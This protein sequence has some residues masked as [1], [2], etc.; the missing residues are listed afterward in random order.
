MDLPVDTDTA[1]VYEIL[2]RIVNNFDK[3]AVRVRQGGRL[4]WMPLNAVEDQ[5]LVL[6]LV[7]DLIKQAAAENGIRMRK[8]R[9]L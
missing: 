5:A 1:T 2:Q 6:K 3:L 9:G 7:R 8:G 4:Q